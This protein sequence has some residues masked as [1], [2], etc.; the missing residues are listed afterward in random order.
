MCPPVITSRLPR[1]HPPRLMQRWLMR[2]GGGVRSTVT[3][4]RRS[5]APCRMSGSFAST[6]C[7]SV[8]PIVPVGSCSRQP[9]VGMQCRHGAGAQ[10]STIARRLLQSTLHHLS[11]YT[12]AAPCLAT[13]RGAARPQTLSR[14]KASPLWQRLTEATTTS[15]RSSTPLCGRPAATRMVLP[16]KGSR[17]SA[18]ARKGAPHTEGSL[19]AFHDCSTQQLLPT[20]GCS[21][22][23]GTPPSSSACRHCGVQKAGSCQLCAPEDRPGAEPPEAPQPTEMPLEAGCAPDT[24]RRPAGPGR[25]R[26]ERCRTQ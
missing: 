17:S 14:T 13:N 15:R 9:G 3:R 7:V 11:F 4:R 12:D 16:R 23:K 10:P 18:G 8:P 22:S 6:E 20:S 5:T 2:R 25:L 19:A 24:A 21:P 1:Q 26:W